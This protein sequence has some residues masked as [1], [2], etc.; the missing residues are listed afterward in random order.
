MKKYVLLALKIIPLLTII[1]GIL[2]GGISTGPLAD[3]LQVAMTQYE[4]AQILK[5]IGANPKVLT[6]QENFESFLQENFHNQYSILA[7]EIK[8]E[9]SHNLSKDIWGKPFHLQVMIDDNKVKMGSSGP[10]GV[11]DTKDD[12]VAVVTVDLSSLK[13]T[14]KKEIKIKD[15]PLEEFQQI[16]RPELTDDMENEQREPASDESAQEQYAAENVAEQPYSAADE[17][18]DT[19]EEQD[20]NMDQRPDDNSLEEGVPRSEDQGV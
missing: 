13:K 20:E 11:I 4:V 10:D 3:A 17:V 15:A 5:V 2:N 7:R 18:H 9:K 6:G 16:E 12:V 1:H 8:G 14:A 19:R